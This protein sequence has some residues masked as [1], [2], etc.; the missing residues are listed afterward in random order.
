MREGC[1]IT[2]SANPTY[3]ANPTCRS[4][5][6]RNPRRAACARRV[7]P[8]YRRGGSTYRRDGRRHVSRR[9]VGPMSRSMLQVS[10]LRVH[11]KLPRRVPWGPHSKVHAVDGISFDVPRGTTFGL[12]G[13]SGSGKSTTALAVMRLVDITGGWIR[14]GDTVLSELEGDTLRQARRDFQ[15]IFQDP[16]SSLNPR[17]RAGDMVREP[18]DLMR[19]EPAAERDDRVA[20]LFTE[21][22]LRPEQRFLFPHQFS[23]PPAGSGNGLEWR[24]RSRPTRDWWFATNR[25]RPS[26]SRSRP[27]SSTC[28]T[29]AA[30]EKPDLPVHLSRP[31]RGAVHLRRDRGDVPRANRGAGGSG[32]AV[33]HPSASLHL[34]VALGGAVGAAEDRSRVAAGPPG[35]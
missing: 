17:T 26:T 21:V 7:G 11:F 35:G 30:G 22:G 28:S 14:L 20:E 16:Y 29:P 33:H 2:P 13:E 25:S 34:G 5:D 15:I 3:G 6:P 18:L 1:R 24:G 23:D 4:D 9:R 32:I 10:D 19:V 27:R 31:G 12:V 8:S